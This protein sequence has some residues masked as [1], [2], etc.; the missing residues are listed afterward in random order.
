MGT[1]KPSD[2]DPLTPP[3]LAKRLGLD[4]PRG[5]KVKRMVL[6]WERK[7]GEHAFVRSGSAKKPSYK[8][9]MKRFKG[10]FPKQFSGSKIERIAVNVKPYLHQ[11]DTRAEKAMSEYTS[12]HI[13]PQINTLEKYIKTLFSRIRELEKRLK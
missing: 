5:E 13:Q 1:K 4:D 3:Q 7:H 9:T 11:F 2:I 8:I 10:L 6:S 12:E